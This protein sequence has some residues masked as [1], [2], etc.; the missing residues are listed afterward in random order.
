MAPLIMEVE[1]IVKPSLKNGEA[2]A[3]LE[4]SVHEEHQYL[5]LIREILATG[6]HRP[7]R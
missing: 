7:D 6:E 2:A 4:Q 5:D 3:V 1:P